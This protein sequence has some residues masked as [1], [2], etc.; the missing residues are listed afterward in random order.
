MQKI[1]KTKPIVARGAAMDVMEHRSHEH[2]IRVCVICKR[3]TCLFQGSLASS[4]SEH[5]A[6]FEFATFYFV[7]VKAYVER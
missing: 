6:P 7:F 3:K 5:L 2:S 1:I 4:C